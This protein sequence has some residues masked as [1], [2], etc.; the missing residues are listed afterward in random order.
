MT[1][2]RNHSYRKDIGYDSD[3]MGQVA[4]QYENIFGVLKEIITR[5]STVEFVH[6]TFSLNAIL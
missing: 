3:K 2:G 1:P 5:L 6:Y 4:L